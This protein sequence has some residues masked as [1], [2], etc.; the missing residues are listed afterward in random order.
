M[1]EWACVD[2][3]AI[4]SHHS[5]QS[6]LHILLFCLC[7][8]IL[9][10]SGKHTSEV[11]W[12]RLFGLKNDLQL[13]YILWGIHCT[14]YCMRLK[15]GEHSHS[16]SLSVLRRCLTSFCSL[17]TP[18]CTID[19][20]PIMSHKWKESIKLEQFIQRS[21]GPV[22]LRIYIQHN[23]IKQENELEKDI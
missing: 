20:V 2:C 6:D 1:V 13:C 18:L 9:S 3:V 14:R 12:C 22:T 10:S 4:N 17:Y 16:Y 8:Q 11:S 5:P 23:I 7:C 19:N 15:H 21:I